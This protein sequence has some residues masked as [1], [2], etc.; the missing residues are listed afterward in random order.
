MIAFDIEC[1]CGYSFEAWF[2][3]HEDFRAQQRLGLIAC[4]ACGG[5]DTKKIP[6]PVTAIRTNQQAMETAKGEE[7]S[8]DTEKAEVLLW[9]IQN[10]VR[11]HYED[12]GHKL[13]DEALKIHYGVTKPR[14]LRG[15]TTTQEEEMLQD[16]GI[17]LI[18]IPM[19]P[20]DDPVN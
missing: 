14:N 8:T 13:A 12:V 20:Q 18:K 5:Q 4:P 2:Q 7:T 11:K 10:Y 15:V 17:K 6:S 16:E 19:P 1:V 9:M 3:S